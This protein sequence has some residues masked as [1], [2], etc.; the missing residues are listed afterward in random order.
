VKKREKLT[1]RRRGRRVE[2]RTKD[3]GLKDRRYRKKEAS[4]EWDG[5]GRRSLQ[6]EESGAG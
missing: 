1:Q 4:S 3:A 6:R 2:E 5:L